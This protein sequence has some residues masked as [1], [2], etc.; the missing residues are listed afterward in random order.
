MVNHIVITGSHVMENYFQEICQ[1]VHLHKTLG[2]EYL[3]QL[4]SNASVKMNE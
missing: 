2:Y 4:D 1:I 3:G